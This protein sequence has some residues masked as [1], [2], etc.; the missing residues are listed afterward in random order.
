MNA[1]QTIC[2]ENALLVPNTQEFPPVF[3]GWVLVAGQRILDLGE[4]AAP[5]VAY[6]RRIDA[7]GNVLMPGLA[8]THAHSHSSLTRGSAEGLPLGEWLK[9]LEKEQTQLTAEQEYI[10]AR[11]TYAEALLSGTTLVADMCLHPKAALRAAC[12]IGLR[13]VIA[14]YVASTKQFTP[15]LKDTEELLSENSLE[16]T[17]QIWCGLH[18]IESAGDSQIREGV[19][20]ARKYS[21]GLHMHCSETLA[22]VRLTEA[23]T[24]QR[25][26]EHLEQLG[27][28]NLQ[29]VLAHCVW[30]DEGEMDRLS[31]Y[32]VSVAHCPHA[33]LKLGSGIAPVPELIEAGVNVTLGTDGAKANNRLDMFDVMK[34]ASLLHK[35]HKRNPSLLPADKVIDMATGAGARALGVDAGTIIPG[36]FADLILVRVHQLHLQPATPETIQTN[37]VHAARGADVDLVMVNGRI[38]VEEGCLQSADQEEI[39]IRLEETGNALMGTTK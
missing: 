9:L 12:D 31:R 27:V 36:A 4:G 8:N 24:G 35:G 33:N 7:G 2:I 20:L 21:S 6:D 34:F 5:K 3:Q 26:V 32:G 22:S 13:V 38:V 25:P 1:E 19:E 14:P 29:T 16:A 23:R 30:V 10:A 37:L 17:T 15:T 39:L 11:A 18:D 28:L